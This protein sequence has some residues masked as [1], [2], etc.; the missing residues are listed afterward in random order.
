MTSGK[1][2][3]DTI[4]F[5]RRLA[6][7]P[8]RV[9]RAWADRKE[10]IQWD[11]PGDDWVIAEFSQGFKEDGVEHSRFGPRENPDAESYGRYLLIVPNRRIV[12]AGVMRSAKSGAASSTTMMTLEFEPDGA[13]TLL[14]LIDQSVFL[15]EGETAEMRGSGWSSILDKLERFLAA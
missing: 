12:S 8:E 15:G 9:F 4:T 10:R 5:E 7:A 3:P 13:G 14:T 1:I 2:T 11:V 6:A